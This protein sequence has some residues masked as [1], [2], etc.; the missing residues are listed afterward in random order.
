[1]RERALEFAKA[2]RREPGAQR[3][4]T[5]STAGRRVALRDPKMGWQLLYRRLHAARNSSLHA[6]CEAQR[7]LRGVHKPRL[8]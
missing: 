7:Q 3:W 1:M 5:T 6:L 8:A 4:K 2:A